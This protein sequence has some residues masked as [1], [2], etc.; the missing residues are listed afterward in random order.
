MKSDPSVLQLGKRLALIFVLRKNLRKAVK[1]LVNARLRTG[2]HDLTWND[3]TRVHSVFV[4]NEAKSVHELDLSDFASSM[5]LKVGL[6]LSLGGIA[7]K[8]A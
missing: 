2:V 8:V 4:L 6:N 3:V 5:S 7:R 1:K